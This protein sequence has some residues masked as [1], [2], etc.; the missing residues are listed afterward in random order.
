MSRSSFLDDAKIEI[1]CA[2]CGKKH[3]K[4]LGWCK[5]YQKITCQCGLTITLDL[6][7][8]NRSEGKVN[9]ALKDL[10]REIAALNHALK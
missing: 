6:S 8:F 9:K 3:V 5:R 4:T 2:D 10:D 1:P 7:E